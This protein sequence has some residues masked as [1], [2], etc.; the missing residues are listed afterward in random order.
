MRKII[1]FAL[2]GF[3]AQL[4]DGSLGMGFG[5]S[6]SS[7]LLTF[8]VAPAIASATIHFSEILTTAASGASHLKF[9]NVHK[10]SVLKLAIPG[11]I[12]AFI[13]ASFLSNIHSENI[14]PFI[15]LFLLS[16]GVYIIYQF[17]V[18]NTKTQQSVKGVKPISNLILIPQAALAGFL[19]SVGGGGWGPVNT[20]LLLAS[21]KLEPRYVIGTVSASEFFVTISASLGFLIFLDWSSIN[22]LLVISLSVGGVLAAPLSAWLVKSLPL[23]VLAVGVGGLIIFTNINVLL[24]IFIESS[25]AISIIKS[26]V[27]IAWI[28]LVITVFI[29]QKRLSIKQSNVNA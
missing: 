28:S 18:K 22:W 8:G 15:S 23:N 14:K 25:L 5:A 20:P 27:V 17:I 2:A 26:L 21:K 13:G 24:G 3:L 4:V 29:K 11:A 19:D 6:S 1:I 9:K 7:V 16:L 12:T 10:P